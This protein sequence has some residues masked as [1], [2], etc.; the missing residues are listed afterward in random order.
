[1]KPRNNIIRKYDNGEIV[2]YTNPKHTK[3]ISR[4]IFSKI[5]W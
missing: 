4:K 5:I 3:S 1:M 2:I